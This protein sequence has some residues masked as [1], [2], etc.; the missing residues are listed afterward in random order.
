MLDFFLRG[1]ENQH[2]DLVCLLF[3]FGCRLTSSALCLGDFLP[4]TIPIILTPRAARDVLRVNK[5]IG[6]KLL[7]PLPISS[8]ASV[9]QS[10]KVL[11]SHVL[12]PKSY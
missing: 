8:V 4:R 12:S 10:E 2:G 6:F 11:H 1:A 7:T 9:L 3:I 5:N